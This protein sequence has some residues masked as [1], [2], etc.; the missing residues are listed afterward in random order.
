MDAKYRSKFRGLKV[1]N[2]NFRLPA[3]LYMSYP[4]YQL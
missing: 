1:V 2:I 3:L 4:L